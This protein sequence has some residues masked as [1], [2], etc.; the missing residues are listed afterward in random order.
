M[1][2][3]SFNAPDLSQLADLLPGYDFEALIAAGGMGAVYKARQRSL[4]RNVAIKVLPRELGEDPEFRQS[5]AQE[6]RA[7]ARLNHPNLIGVYDSGNVDGML[8][9]VM[10]YV[11]G[12]SLFHSAYQSKIEPRQAV[13]IILGVCAGL[14]HA[15][16]NGIIHRD[17]KPANILLTPK[18]EPKV[19]DFGLARPAGPDSPGLIMGTPGYMAPEVVERPEHAD[20]RS[21]LYAVGVL[22]YELL[23]GGLP[24]ADPVAPSR[25]CGCDPELDEICL[26]AMAADPAARFSSAKEMSGRL[27]RWLKGPAPVA[28]PARESQPVEAPAPVKR[29]VRVGFNWILLR[30]LVVIAVLLVMIRWTWQFTRVQKELIERDARPPSSETAMATGNR[31]EEAKTPPEAVAPAGDPMAL[32]ENP[33]GPEGKIA[34]ETVEETLERLRVSLLA[35]E[36]SEFP[37][38]TFEHLDRWFLLVEKPLTWYE[39][40]IFAERHGGGLSSEPRLEFRGFSG[41]IWQGGYGGADTGWKRLDGSKWD[42]AETVKGTGG[43]L[44]REPD[45]SIV[46]LDGGERLPFVIEWGTEKGPGLEE[47]LEDAGQA[48]I[49]AVPAVPPG[50]VEYGSS[51]FLVLPWPVDAKEA[52]RLAELAGGSLASLP[53]RK[54]AAFLDEMLDDSGGVFWIGALRTAGGWEWASGEEWN[55][56]WW[57]ES[58]STDGGEDAAVLVPGEGW[59]ARPS[60]LPAD[61]FIIEWNA[62]LHSEELA[63]IRESRLELETKAKAL[64]ASLDAELEKQLSENARDCTWAL[65]TWLRTMSTNESNRWRP[66]VERLKALI[67]DHRVPEIIRPV[68]RVEL[69]GQMRNILERCSERQKSFDGEFLAKVRPIHT[70]YLAKIRELSRKEGLP[71]VVLR[72]LESYLERAADLN[73]WLARLSG[74]ET[75]EQVL[76]IVKA[77]YGIRGKDAD[78]TERLRE[79]VEEGRGFLANPAWLGTDPNPGWPK[80]LTVEYEWK[81]KLYRKTWRE[82]SQ[83]LI[84]DFEPGGGEKNP[85]DN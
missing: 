39:A 65:D 50:A 18:A 31:G 19:G 26:K 69:S 3:P 13:E 11:H 38:G 25:L 73:T 22:L 57:A 4:D 68:H 67:V 59:M 53:E 14:Q 17:I 2:A 21:D 28:A 8:F 55:E 54:K 85:L 46:S 79:L 12:K 75:R 66:E 15:H 44:A 33:P 80:E 24:G 77:T 20:H 7:M 60:S 58:G 62:G 51:H 81:G 1:S 83:V 56:E 48:A 16:E 41:R 29:Q 47:L 43:F 9:M 72:E 84:A 76:K 49:G 40:A 36:R 6:A 5:F 82:L 52:A 63:E 32:M 34:K 78:V 70:A 27:E 74:A 10:E 42:M 71:P 61:G 30:N 64:L 35:G 45:R 37:E 23:T